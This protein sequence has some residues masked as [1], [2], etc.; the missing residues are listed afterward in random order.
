MKIAEWQGDHY[1][2]VSDKIVEALS[3]N[4]SWGEVG[5]GTQGDDALPYEGFHA[6]MPLRMK[7]AVE[8]IEDEGGGQIAVDI[9]VDYGA[10]FF[11]LLQERRR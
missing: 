5:E 3:S 7:K 1:V 6:I 4:C 11:R 9:A 8:T 2:V 10:P